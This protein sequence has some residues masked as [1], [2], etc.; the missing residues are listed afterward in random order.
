MQ[1]GSNLCLKYLM[2]ELEPSEIMYMKK[3]LEEDEDLLIELESMRFTL[4]RLEKLDTIDPPREVSESIIN[5]AAEY[6]ALQQSFNKSV[7]WNKI[8]MYVAA[9]VLLITVIGFSN[10]FNLSVI[11]S[12]TGIERQKDK[13]KAATPVI[14]STQPAKLNMDN[15]TQQ[16]LEPWIDRNN[17]LRMEDK[18][19]KER[20]SAF[21]SAMNQS[22]QKLTPVQKLPADRLHISESK[23]RTQFNLIG[24]NK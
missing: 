12:F 11:D 7:I 21:D 19:N 5:K 14:N 9:A 16:A 24:S 6:H 13:T 8:S 23:T 1:N 18:F 15:R 3:A 20:V 10:P 4:E 17:I 22:F 2:D